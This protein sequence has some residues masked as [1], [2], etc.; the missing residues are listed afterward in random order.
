[1]TNA[2]GGA[3]SGGGGAYAPNASTLN[4][5]YT[6][7]AAEI[8]AG[9]LWLY[10]TSTGNGGCLSSRDS[11]QV[12]FTPAPTANAGADIFLCAN[13]PNVSLNGAVTIATGGAWS[14]GSGSLHAERE[15]R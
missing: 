7:T 6:P 14:G 12:Q 1:V 2:T 8:A 3:W 13:T 15:H 10:L 5:V 9:S 11:L 4:T